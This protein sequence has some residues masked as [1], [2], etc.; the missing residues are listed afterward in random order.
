MTSL[1]LERALLPDGRTAR[2]TI[3]D[4]LVTAIEEAGPPHSDAVD[5]DGALLLPSL[6]DGHVHLDK[7]FIGDGW[8]PHVPAATIHERIAIEQRLLDAAA[9][10]ATRARALIEASVVRG[11]TAI[12][13][14][15]DV[16]PVRGL[17]HVEAVAEVRDQL[18]HLVS[19]QF[20]AFPQ[21]GLIT[22][23]GTLELMEA[24]F[25]AGADVV[26]G[27]D[28]AT[29]DRDV[30]GQLDAIFE[31]A[32]R[33]GV[34]VDIHLHDAG[35]LGVFQLEAIADRSRALGMGGRVAVSHAYCLGMISEVEQRRTAGV[36]AEAGI[37]IM[38]NAPGDHAFP[39]VKL[40]RDAGVEVFA[41]NDNIRDAWW[42][43]GDADMLERSMLIG[44]RSGFYLDEE[45]E[46]A[47]DLA[48]GAARRALGLEPVAVAV[49][50]PADLI[51]VR[52]SCVAE[53]VVARPARVL[54][55]KAGRTVAKNGELRV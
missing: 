8:R 40:L 16:D 48:S 24:A 41:G 21:H 37:A 23:P 15:V 54:V 18:S 30:D 4:G 35:E 52:A 39:P 5:L 46:L 12:R 43:Y 45:L 10:V 31:L 33:R 51:A 32:E 49:G 34:P 19:I 55:M 9:P 14:H 11:T 26:G 29:F 2:V 13:S 7:C 36:L 6:V 42:P 47:F 1:V 3:V 17:R 44:Y 38:T 25:D 53:A 50:C 22:N 20:V 27:L 28:P